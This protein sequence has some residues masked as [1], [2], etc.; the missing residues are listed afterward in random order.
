MLADVE[1]GERPP[2]PPVLHVHAVL[3]GTYLLLRL[4]QTTLAATG[5]QAWHQRLGLAA[6]RLLVMSWPAVGSGWTGRSGWG[7][8]LVTRSREG[9]RVVTVR[10]S[11]RGGAGAA[12]DGA[13]AW[14]RGFGRAP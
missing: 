9:R 3:M 6:S 11:G 14:G 7:G 12:A 5:R 1:A 10:A 4:A 8:A 2:L 13:A